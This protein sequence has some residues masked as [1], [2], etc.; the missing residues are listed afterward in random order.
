VTRSKTSRRRARRQRPTYAQRIKTKPT[1][2]RTSAPRAATKA[3]RPAAP[4][5]VAETPK[6]TPVRAPQ[7]GSSELQQLKDELQR[8]NQEISRLARASRPDATRQTHLPE[9]QELLR[10]KAVLDSKIRAAAKA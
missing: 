1:K 4:K 2:T 9:K 3:S 10:Q 8:V 6:P 5:V 7:T